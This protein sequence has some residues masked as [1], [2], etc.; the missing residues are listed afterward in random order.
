MNE[1]Q[2]FL[3]TRR[4]IRRFKTKPV[5]ASVIERILETA[6]YAPSAHNLQPWR[7]ALIQTD[8]AKEKLG[9]ALTNKMCADMSAENTPYSKEYR[10]ADI[11]KRIKISLR[12]MDEAPVIILLCRDKTILSGDAPEEKIM[13]I[14]STA[15]AG[16]QLLL[17][18][19]AENISANWICWVLYAQKETINAL[20]LPE[21][22]LP[23]AMFFLGNADEEPDEKAV[24]ELSEITKKL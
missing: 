20:N 6:T 15:L 11:D 2:T 17:S 19:H 1:F 21:N 14:Q 24:K 7:F 8:S 22:W 23:E 13:A 18:A 10:Q 9:T 5:P 12:R 4:S 3:R 16:L